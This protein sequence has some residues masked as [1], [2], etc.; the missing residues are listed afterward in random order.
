MKKRNSK[1]KIFFSQF[2]QTVMF[3]IL[4]IIYLVF[5]GLIQ[6]FGWRI[7]PQTL[8]RKIQASLTAI[9]IKITNFL[10]LK[11]AG[12]IS[13][14]NLIELSIRNMK[15]KKT[16]T[17]MTVGGMTIGIGTIVFLVS[18][19][20]G[21]QELVI[22]R[23]ARLEEMKQTDVS[24]QTGS[25]IKINDKTLSDFKDITSVDMALPLI[26]VVGRVSYQNSVSDMAVYGVTTDYLKQ[27][28]VQP[29]KGKIFDSN[30]LVATLS[31]NTGSGEVAGV[32]TESAVLGDTIQKINFN[33]KPSTWL[34]VRESPATTAKIIGYTKRVEGDSAGEEV[35]GSKYQ[36]D[37]KTG[38]AGTTSDG[39]TLGKWIKAPILLWKQENCDSQTQG[40]CEDG[41]YVVLRDT[42][43]KQVQEDGY[44]AELSVTLSGSS[45][46]NGQVLGDSTDGSSVANASVNW[47][48]IASE[49]GTVTQPETKTVDL[50]SEAKKQAVV[51]QAMLKV[52]GINEN[53]AVGKKF[54]VSF[55]VVGDLLTDPT[56]KVESSANDYTIVGVTPGENTPILYVPF[57][58]L[59]TLGVTNYSQIK[60]VSKDQTSL[61]KIRKQI[62]AMGYTTRSVADTVSQIN[63]LFSTAKALLLLLGMVSLAVAALGMFNTL[64]VSL[65]ERTREV[66][67]MKA[68][69]MKS[70]EIKELF[71]TE[72]LVMGLLGGILGI[73]VGFVLGKV[74]GLILS[75]FTFFKGLG[76]I[77]ISYLPFSF[78]LVVLLL[79]LLVGLITGIYPAKR[80]TKISALNALRYE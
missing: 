80:A 15:A 49:S 77:S 28:A 39:K 6:V 23:V 59:R 12:S 78:I 58:D 24:P 79:S 33:I 43:N 66:G 42:D 67:L 65:L 45:I 51:N 44:V 26:A 38:E 35:W 32:M 72:S 13:R 54:S 48:V 34:K 46:A 50:T 56:E 57:I 9:L 22:N 29:E 64:T 75:F 11:R 37:D 5:K 3:I 74:L 52:L 36:S 55:V 68:L 30:E 31:Q 70:S 14:V 4:L 21:L 7:W 19:G 71:L 63:S 41:K 53:E 69:G 60:V 2:G 10:D 73:I 76:Y 20:Y 25:K 17:M 16:R 40:D 61:A 1:I 8:K 47:V 27:S 18:I 62:E